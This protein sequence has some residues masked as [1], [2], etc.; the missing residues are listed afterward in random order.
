MQSELRRDFGVAF[1]AWWEQAKSALALRLRAFEV[2]REARNTV[3]K[4]GTLS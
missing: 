1:D 2:I 4:R 3:L